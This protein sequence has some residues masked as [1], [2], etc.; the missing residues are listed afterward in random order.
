MNSKKRKV[1]LFQLLLLLVFDLS[2]VFY[3][4]YKLV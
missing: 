2:I 1:V 4:I 3:V